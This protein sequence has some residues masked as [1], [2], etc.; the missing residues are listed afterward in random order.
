L[1]TPLRLVIFDVD[2]TLIDSQAHILAAMARAFD[3][4][5]LPVPERSAVLGVVGLSLPVLVAHLA[6]AADAT[7]Q[8]RIIEGYKQG[9]ADLRAEGEAGMS[10]LYPGARAA[11]DALAARDDTLMAVA[12]GKS[13]RGMAHVIEMHGLEGVFQSVQTADDHPS[14]PSPEMIRACLTETGVAPRD[15]AILGDTAFDME[16]GRNAGI[17]PIGVTW[18][19]H[20]RKRIFQAG[21]VDLLEDFSALMPCLDRLWGLQ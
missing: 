3:G 2:G 18:G 17:H 21:A 8:G 10:P 20:N 5:G 12:T 14:K 11:L 16:M 19:Y 15:A 9:F 7:T 13:R 6:P 1:S 4:V